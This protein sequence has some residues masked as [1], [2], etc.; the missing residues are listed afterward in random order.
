V[1]TLLLAAAVR[2]RSADTSLWLDEIWSIRQVGGL[3][4]PGQILTRI[5]SDSNHYLNSLWLYLVGSKGNWAG[6]RAPAV[7]AGVGATAL[8]GWIGRRRSP[9]TG[10]FALLL[11]GFSYVLIV[12][13]SEA[14]G[15]A[16]L[17]LFALLAY[18]ALDR[19]LTTHRPGSGALF[20]CSATLGLLSHLTFAGFLIAAFP[21]ALLRLRRSHRPARSVVASLALCFVLPGAVFA[22][23]Y[24]VDLR[25]LEVNGGATPGLA[26]CAME[27]LAWTLGHPGGN[28]LAA[29]VAAASVAALALVAGLAFLARTDPPAIVLFG[30]T[31][32]VA[33]VLLVLCSG[34]DVLYVRYFIV[35]I[36]FL[37]VLLSYVLGALYSSGRMGRIV[38]GVLLFG[39]LYCNG[40]QLPKLFALGRGDNAGA[41]AYL[42][43]HSRDH[44]I[45]VTG[46][47]DF[48]IGTVVEF[49]RATEPADRSLRYLTTT[50]YSDRGVEWLVCEQE[51]FKDPT[52]PDREYG[53]AEGHRFA[54]VKTFPAA[55][56]SGLHWF[57]YHNRAYDGT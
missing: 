33:P 56:L 36:L 19:H 50:Q 47:I 38:S 5:H 42:R 10:L 37:L 41:I 17:T 3:T 16:T 25:F 12:Y 27:S 35:P 9:A 15:Y 28:A 39:Y 30:G 48:R 45:T 44:P 55:P 40:R 11:T 31:I 14:R 8:A 2:M 22:L 6:Y 13:S 32:V 18:G 29:T 53:D 46:D 57:I 23:L 52:P 26:R 4:S 21:W 7:F 1:A 34:S 54:F 20:S 43:D 49:F 51:S 24:A